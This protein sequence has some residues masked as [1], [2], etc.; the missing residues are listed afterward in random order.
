M[1]LWQNSH[2]F[3]VIILQKYKS[4]RHKPRFKWDRVVLQY[5]VIAGLIQFVFHLMQIPH[6]VILKSVVFLFKES[7]L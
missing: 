2:I 3:R 4:L 7:Q 6:F 5:A 1:Y